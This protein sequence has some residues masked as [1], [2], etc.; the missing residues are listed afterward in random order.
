MVVDKNIYFYLMFGGEM[1]FMN[2][3][4]DIMVF[5]FGEKDESDD[6]EVGC[7]GELYGYFV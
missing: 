7:F 5:V 4:G 2:E 3:V 1:I 6:D